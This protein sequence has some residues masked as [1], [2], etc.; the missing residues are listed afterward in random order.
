MKIQELNPL[1]ESKVIFKLS[2][3][4]L[5][6]KEAGCYV[7]TTFE[8]DILYIGLSE[9]LFV[10]FQQHLGNSEKTLPTKEGKVV[11]FHYLKYDL[12]NLPKLE[13]SWINSFLANQGVLPTLNKISSPLY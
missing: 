1:P 11:W 10:R 8:G 5:V 4:K 3:F 9:N 6:P 2:S 12:Y 13:R 7:L